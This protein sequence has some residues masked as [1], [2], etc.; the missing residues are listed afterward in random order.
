MKLLD[1]AKLKQSL[2]QIENQSIEAL[3]ELV[4][5]PSVIGDPAPAAP[6]G[7][8]I[9]EALTNV[10]ELCS[11]LGFRTYQDPE[12]YYGYAEIGE[13]R[14][15]AGIL[16][17]L[18]VVPPGSIG[19]WDTGPFDPAEREGK[20]FGR[21]TQDDKG[22]VIA[23]IFAA[24]ALMD[25]GVTFHKR[26][27]FIFGTDEETLWRCMEKY[28]EKEEAPHMGFTPDSVFPLVYA[29]KGLLQVHLTAQNTSTLRI[30]GGS[31]FNAVPDSIIY[32]GDNQ[33]RIKAELDKKGYPYN[34]VHDGLEVI[35]KAAHAQAAEKGVNAISRLAIALYNA[36]FDSKAIRFIAELAEDDPHAEAIFGT[37]EDKHS[38]KLKFNIGKMM[39]NEEFEQLSID[40]RIPVTVRK[41]EVVEKLSSAAS[42]FGLDYEEF[43][44]LKSIYHPL[45]HPL[46]ET[47][48]EVYRDESGDTSSEPISSGGA[49]Y[50]RAIDNC[51]A[52]GA[53]FPWN[54]K[55]EHQPNEHI[56]LK[57]YR[58]AMH[59]YAK[60][61][62]KLTQG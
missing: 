11:R 51:V 35:G 36:G 10:L 34:E 21:G 18:D 61:I 47:L 59:I 6:F 40:I 1:E 44:W 4:R 37:C 15:M 33:E 25:Q 22:P 60:A 26:L 55:V 2:Q 27:R 9:G 13:G 38:G 19:D 41:E 23:S 17:H 12:G 49:T 30:S 14:E 53:L 31:A 42:R 57:D 7:T 24:R 20:L 58:K 43:D 3:K 48:L 56:V 54:E 50:A 29:E 28:K 39:L 46:I 52:F 5:I 45:D 62:Y 32:R 8:A 16:G